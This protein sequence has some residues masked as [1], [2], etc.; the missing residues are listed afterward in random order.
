MSYPERVS[1]WVSDT[2]Y[3]V[4][5]DTEKVECTIAPHCH[6][7]DGKKRIAQVWLTT[8]TFNMLPVDMSDADARRILNAINE[9]HSSLE[10]AY[11]FNSKYGLD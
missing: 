6:I 3:Y 1:F 7:T 8:N 4:E 10:Y 5:V 11:N 9:Q 2:K